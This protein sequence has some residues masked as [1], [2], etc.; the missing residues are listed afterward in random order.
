MNDKLHHSKQPSERTCEGAI[1]TH[2]GR[3][4]THSFK[5]PIQLQCD[6]D[7]H[8]ICV[9]NVE[10]GANTASISGRTPHEVEA[11]VVRWCVDRGLCSEPEGEFLALAD[12]LP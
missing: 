3:T 2:G 9:A 4:I 10:A 11:E 6:V 5:T 7:D 8:G 1:Y 12:L